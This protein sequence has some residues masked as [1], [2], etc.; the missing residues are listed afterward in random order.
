VA[1]AD[2]VEILFIGFDSF[3]SLATWDDA[4]IIAPGLGG[5]EDVE[6]TFNPTAFDFSNGKGATV[7]A[8]KGEEDEG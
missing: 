6:Q 4:L 1:L 2:D 8:V 7:C 3:P 5:G